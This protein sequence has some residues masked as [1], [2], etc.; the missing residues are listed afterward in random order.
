MLALQCAPVSGR[1][2]A[3]CL[4]RSAHR[5]MSA[6]SAPEEIRQSPSSTT[7][8]GRS[9]TPR[10]E[11]PQPRNR[12]DGR[13]AGRERTRRRTR[14]N[15]PRRRTARPHIGHTHASPTKPA[16]SGQS[17]ECDRLDAVGRWPRP[18]RCAKVRLAHPSL[19]GSIRSMIGSFADKRTEN[20]FNGVSE[21][22]FPAS[23]LPRARSK[24]GRI[25]DA[26][27]LDDLRAPPGNRLE[28]LAGGR[29]GQHSIRVSRGWRICFV[30]RDRD[31]WNVELN[32]HYS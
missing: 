1:A 9:S 7:E 20:V 18:G 4:R 22:S 26:T 32:N 13:A 17:G 5:T 29:A 19:H 15:P 6:S 14:R 8:T 31:A 16:S 23:I 25:N 24:L 12:R 11:P 21:R 10:A 30:W 3:A 27:R 28:A 2:L